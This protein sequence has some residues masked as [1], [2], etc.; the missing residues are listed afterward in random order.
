[1]ITGFLHGRAFDQ[2]AIDAM[3]L[4]FEDALR[5]LGVVNRQDPIVQQVAHVIIECAERGMRDAREMRDC[6]LEAIRR[7]TG[8]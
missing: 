3:T 8:V 5:E 4:A 2:E 6:A 1:V 7:G